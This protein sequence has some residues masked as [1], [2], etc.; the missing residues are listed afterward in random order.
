MSSTQLRAIAEVIGVLNAFVE[1]CKIP[2]EKTTETFRVPIF[3]RMLKIVSSANSKHE[4][5]PWP[6]DCR[7]KLALALSQRGE[8]RFTAELHRCR[9]ETAK[10]LLGEIRKLV[11]G[12]RQ[13]HEESTQCLKRT[14]LFVEATS[15]KGGEKP[16]QAERKKPKKQGSIKQY[17]QPGDKCI[18]LSD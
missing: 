14:M 16:P 18:V 9:D 11:N 2:W 3:R 7:K 12:V 13:E 5:Q 1:N 17:M 4:E 6:L 8:R 10:R 15:E